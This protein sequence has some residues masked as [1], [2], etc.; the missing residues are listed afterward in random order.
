MSTASKIIG[1]EQVLEVVVV[2]GTTGVPVA[3]GGG[4]TSGG[5]ITMAQPNAYSDGS[6]NAV[7]VSDTNPFPTISNTPR[8]SL[9]DRSAL[10]TT[11]GTSQQLAA[12]NPNRKY[13]LVVNP[14]VATE[15]LYINFTAVAT[16]VT[17]ATTLT[18]SIPIAPGG[19]YTMTGFISTEIVNVIAASTSHS[20]VAKEG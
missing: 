2:D 8:G 13:L 18:S 4:T 5:T 19:S 7:F 15:N 14:T 17:G 6:G 1:G 12:A 10:I 11:G 3:V 16:A 9:T 20:F